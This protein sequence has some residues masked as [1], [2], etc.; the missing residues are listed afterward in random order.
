MI[1]KTISPTAQLDDAVLI[2]GILANNIR[3]YRLFQN[4]YFTYIKHLFARWINDASDAEELSC[5]VMMKVINTIDRFDAAKGNMRLW[6][7]V[8]ALNTRND[9]LRKLAA[10]EEE[11]K[12]LS[13][14]EP[15]SSGSDMLR[16]DFLVDTSSD[17]SE[18]S[19]SSAYTSNP[20]LA[21]AQEVING[22]SADT[23]YILQMH[24]DGYMS[25]EIAATVQKPEGTIRSIC[26]R[27]KKVIRTA[28][29]KVMDNK[30]H[31]ALVTE[32][33]R[34]AAP[35]VSRDETTPAVNAPADVCVASSASWRTR[36]HP[37]TPLGNREPLSSMTHVTPAV[38]I[39][40]TLLSYFGAVYR[41]PQLVD[42]VT[43]RSNIVPYPDVFADIPYSTLPT[44]SVLPPVPT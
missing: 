36:A 14:D 3:C 38:T 39:I 22:L 6:I 21:A 31:G 29:D 41:C 13:L 18:S 16:I 20:A 8:I 34:S 32:P 7:Y 19:S 1:T 23:R 30:E 33:C 11:A 17:S 15:V 28:Y 42:I 25:S 5:D 9:Y 43:N 37:S 4:R 27:I 40:R 2:N 24:E 10:R 12:M 44:N 26:S 35:C